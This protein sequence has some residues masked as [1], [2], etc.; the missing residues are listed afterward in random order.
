[1]IKK[2][3]VKI[4]LSPN[5]K[6][7]FSNEKE[8]QHIPDN[9][10]CESKNTRPCSQDF[11][12]KVKSFPS[13]TNSLIDL[14]WD[15]HNKKITIKL[16]ETSNFDV[17]NWIKHIENKNKEKESNP[18][19]LIEPTY[20]EISLKDFEGNYLSNVKFVNLNLNYH[21][22]NLNIEY[23]SNLTHEIILNY[24]YEEFKMLNENQENENLENKDTDVEWQKTNI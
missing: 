10:C 19:H 20:C 15:L 13:L 16:N 2:E 24:K 7:S 11:V 8:G 23:D 6:T 12:F 1:M 9:F 14:D 22:C 4:N 18:S 3:F 21:H 5:D 17:Y